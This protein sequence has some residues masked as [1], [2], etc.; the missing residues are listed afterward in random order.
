MIPKRVA[1]AVWRE[2]E[3]IAASPSSVISPWV[4]GRSMGKT[5]LLLLLLLFPFRIDKTLGGS[6]VAVAHGLSCCMLVI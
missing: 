2:N 1:S 6:G 5:G 3:E 4:S